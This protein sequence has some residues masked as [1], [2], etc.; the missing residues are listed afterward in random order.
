M[1]LYIGLYKHLCVYPCFEIYKL[2]NVHMVS[3]HPVYFTCHQK[4]YI[5]V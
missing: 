5:F 2:L 3:E 1:N 4:C